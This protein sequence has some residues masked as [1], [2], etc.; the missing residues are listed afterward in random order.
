MGIKGG[1]HMKKILVLVLI[2]SMIGISGCVIDLGDGFE[3]DLDE[4]DFKVNLGS[5]KSV[6]LGDYKTHNKVIELEGQEK[7]EVKLDISAAEIEL[8]ASEGKLFEGEVVTNIQN[9]IPRMELDENKLLIKDEFN[10]NSIKK[11]KNDW[12]LK[13]T[14][15]IPLSLDIRT[16]ATKNDFDFTGLQI[17]E[18]E[19][20]INAADTDITFNE[21]NKANFKSFKI[22]LNAG[23]VEVY[24]L[25]KAAPEEIEVEVN[26]ANIEL[27]FGNNITKNMEI[28]LDGNA[29]NVKLDLPSNVGI[30]IEKESSLVSIS[31]NHPS[32]KKTSD[33]YISD[34]YDSAEY[35]VDIEVRGAIFNV[36]IE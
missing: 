24:G 6:E 12:N 14:D 11:F 26:A 23:S 7:L 13:I 18:L 19:M 2:L 17:E 36:N 9:L 22:D 21:K 8:S 30:S 1:N 16:N 31:I 32:L 4:N 27:D 15:R 33:G 20:Y 35:T 29:S 5:N 3:I 10:Y 34:N 25:D 28:H